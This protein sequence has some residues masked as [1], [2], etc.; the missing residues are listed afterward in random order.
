[1]NSAMAGL[2]TTIAFVLRRHCRR[3]LP[4]AQR[5]GALVEYVIVV[6]A[7]LLVLVANPN[8]IQQLLQALREAYTSFVYAL[9][10]SWI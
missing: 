1:M 10:V 3:K 6:L 5:G 4:H 2:T 9:S 7:L 8:V